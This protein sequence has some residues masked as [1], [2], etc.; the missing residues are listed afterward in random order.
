M[1]PGQESS[2][3]PLVPRTGSTSNCRLT[4]TDKG[5]TPYKVAPPAQSARLSSKS[6]LIGTPLSVP[7]ASLRRMSDERKWH[8]RT[9]VQPPPSIYCELC[10]GE[11]RF[12][13]IAADGEV[14][15]M[16]AQVFVCS[17]C[18]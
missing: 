2:R 8:M 1:R 7:L 13:M 3:R 5:R 16:E 17:K 11:L 14:I 9:L 6:L 12:K 15:D 18:G 10:D 4:R